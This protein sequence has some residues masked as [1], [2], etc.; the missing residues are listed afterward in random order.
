MCR[1]SLGTG[2]LQLGFQ[3]LVLFVEALDCGLLHQNRLGHVV[4]RRRLLTHVLLDARLGLRVTR[5]ARVFGLLEA[6]EQAVNQGLFFSVHGATSWGSGT[7]D[8][9]KDGAYRRGIQSLLR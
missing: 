7:S 2:L 4:R 3:L 9:V 6:A 1:L 5:L 8:S